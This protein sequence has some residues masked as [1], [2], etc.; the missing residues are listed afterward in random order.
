MRLCRTILRPPVP[1]NPPPD[2]EISQVASLNMSWAPSSA[3]YTPVSSRLLFRP[4]SSLSLS[5]SSFVLFS[6][7][8]TLP[9]S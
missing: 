1:A 5:A 2:Q 3:I 4:L 9:H 7:K 6:S 8:W